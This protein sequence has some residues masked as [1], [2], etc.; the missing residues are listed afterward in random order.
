MGGR[1]AG[2]P[3]DASAFSGRG[4]AHAVNINA[5]WVDG[6]PAHPD[7]GWARS[8]WDVLKPYAT[9]GLYMS[10]LRDEGPEL[11]SAAY[12]ANYHRLAEIKCRVDPENLF[13]LNQNIVPARL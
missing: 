2:R 4:A 8:T 1:V 7:S 10:F 11:V 3:D 5:A 9:G 12:G 6:G 13:H